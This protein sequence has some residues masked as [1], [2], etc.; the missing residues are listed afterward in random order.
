MGSNQQPLSRIAHGLRESRRRRHQRGS[1]WPFGRESNGDPTSDRLKDEIAW[2]VKGKRV[3]LMYYPDLGSLYEVD[4]LPMPEF[5]L[6]MHCITERLGWE[7]GC[8]AETE[9]EMKPVGKKRL[10][11]VLATLKQKQIAEEGK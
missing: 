9:P 3:L 7:Q 5:N 6:R 11:E 1:C 4:G 8:S 10:I 2:V